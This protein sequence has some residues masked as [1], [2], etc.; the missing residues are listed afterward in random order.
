MKWPLLKLGK[1]ILARN[2]DGTGNKG[3]TIQYQVDL[4][5]RINNKN[6]L[7]CFL[8]MDLG[9]KNTVILGHPWLTKTSTLIDKLKGAKYFSKMDIRWG[10]NNI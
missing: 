4:N 5:L 6:S 8:V 3:G 7:Q 2:T 1:P 10:Y 9:N